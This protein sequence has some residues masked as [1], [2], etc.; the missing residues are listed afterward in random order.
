MTL[1]NLSNI[2]KVVL[3]R[4]GMKRTI[5]SAIG[6]L[7]ILFMFVGFASSTLSCAPNVTS[8]EINKQIKLIA[9]GAQAESTYLWNMLGGTPSS[10]TTNPAIVTYP[11]IGTKTITLTASAPVFSG[12]SRALIT[13]RDVGNGQV[14]QWIDCNGNDR[15]Y[16]KI[17][18]PHNP[19]LPQPI[20]CAQAGSVHVEGNYT[21]SAITYGDSCG[22]TSFPAVTETAACSVSIVDPSEPPKPAVTC[23]N[24]NQIILK[25]YSTNN[26]HAE[27][28]NGTGN[29]P[30]DICYEN[31]FGTQY[32]EANPHI[33][34]AGNSNWVISLNSST[35]S[36]ASNKSTSGYPI[37]VC[38]GDLNC[39]LKSRDCVSPE[40]LVVSLNYT[41]NSHLAN[42][43]SYPYKVCCKPASITPPTRIC[44]NGSID[45]GE[46]CDPSAAPT[47]C[48]ISTNPVCDNTCNCVSVQKSITLA[49]WRNATGNERIEYA[50]KSALIKLF[51][52]T[53]GFQ[54][55]ENL[56]AQIFNST[57]EFL[58]DIGTNYPLSGNNN[59][60]VSANFKLKDL[61]GLQSIIP[62]NKIYFIINDS[63]N[64][65]SKRSYDLEILAI[66]GTRV[67]VSSCILLNETECE[68]YMADGTEQSSRVQGCNDI[69]VQNA[70]VWNSGTRSCGVGSVAI[71]A[72][73]QIEG[74]CFTYY[75]NKDEGKCVDGVRKVKVTVESV[76]GSCTSLT[77]SNPCPQ[78]NICEIPCRNV[79]LLPFFTMADLII[80]VIVII[81]AYLIIFKTKLFKKKGRKK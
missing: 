53:T 1:F 24:P 45:P 41:T 55:N 56:K 14:V 10:A 47:G 34:S 48:T 27:V 15:Y 78:G 76:S 6:F 57:G 17:T 58:V 50:N 21:H 60:K 49:E 19:Y 81:L 32:S 8:Q 36:H 65:I 16:T 70:C 12:C 29:Y 23:A 62:G 61:S 30:I 4:N 44:N 25:L 73:G 39:T 67:G 59:Q 13:W 52:Q 37:N 5:I 26:A 33:C 31:I 35:N 7:V 79:A 43:S 9:Y 64:T 38:Y 11:N 66:G 63:T 77:C 22:T 68:K 46:D 40:K 20:G 72:L 71:N 2:Y 80:T 18:S 51:G 74:T 28:W 54:D 42:D 75:E 69:Y 3:S